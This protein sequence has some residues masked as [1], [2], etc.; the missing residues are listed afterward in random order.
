MLVFLFIF[1]LAL[2]VLQLF[3]PKIVFF[4]VRPFLLTIP[5]TYA[6]L[7][8]SWTQALSLAVGLGFLLD[9]FSS[10]RLGYSSIVLVILVLFILSQTENLKFDYWPHTILLTLLASFLYFLVDYLLFC[11]Q[12]QTWRW[13]FWVWFQMVSQSVLSTFLAL[14]VYALFDLIHTR[15]Q[16]FSEPARSRSKVSFRP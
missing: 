8:L 12:V 10:Q 1:G 4:D 14:P 16:H 2:I 7:R 15:Q 3:I 11:L 9:V 5:V 13:P 6:A